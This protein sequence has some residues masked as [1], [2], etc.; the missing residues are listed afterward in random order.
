MCLMVRKIWYFPK[1]LYHFKFKLVLT[2]FKSNTAAL[3]HMFVRGWLHTQ[4]AR[5]GV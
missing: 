1:I 3:T 2:D 5:M 4:F